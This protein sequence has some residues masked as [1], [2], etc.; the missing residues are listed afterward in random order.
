MTARLVRRVLGRAATPLFRGRPEVEGWRVYP[1]LS[2]GRSPKKVFW[3]V[4]VTCDVGCRNG[5]RGI[6][7]TDSRQ[8]VR[9][10][11]DLAHSDREGR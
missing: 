6:L 3:R 8:A 4:L 7:A 10:N 11:E 9:P 2:G 1:R 5:V